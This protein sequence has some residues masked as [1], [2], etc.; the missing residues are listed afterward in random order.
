MRTLAKQSGQVDPA[1]SRPAPEVSPGKFGAAS[2]VG[3]NGCANRIADEQLAAMSLR[4]A[5]SHVISSLSPARARAPA[6]CS[7]GLV[8]R[9]LGV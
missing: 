6:H 9:L 5:S 4:A 3:W 7:N 8:Q 2:K 1:M